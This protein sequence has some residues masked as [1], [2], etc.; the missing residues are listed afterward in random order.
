MKFIFVVVILF[1]VV[2]KSMDEL[3][4]AYYITTLQNKIDFEEK[5]LE[6]LLDQKQA[7]IEQML[8]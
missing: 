8:I 2:L 4:I 6:S 1:F 5:K 3:F 7:F